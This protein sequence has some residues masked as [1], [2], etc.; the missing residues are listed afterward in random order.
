MA[1]PIAVSWV[2]RCRVDFVVHRNGDSGSTRVAGSISEFRQPSSSGS[3]ISA[4]LRPPPVDRTRR[5][6]PFSPVSLSSSL[7]PR[8]IV[9]RDALV[10]RCTAAIPPRPHDLTSAAIARRR[11]RSF[12]RGSKTASRS[13]IEVYAKT[14][15]RNL[16]FRRVDA[17]RAMVPP[18]E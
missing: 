8:R 12:N 16:M 14:F 13:A 2:A 15:S 7:S 11:S 9:E 17:N 18:G 4:F 1:C 5:L 6:G 3:A 10:A